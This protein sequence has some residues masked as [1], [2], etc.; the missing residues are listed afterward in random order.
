VA[1]AQLDAPVELSGSVR[2]KVKL[3]TKGGGEALVEAFL[4]EK[5]GGL[6]GGEVPCQ[7]R[8]AREDDAGFDAVA[9]A[10]CWC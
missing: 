1:L 9:G 3:G 2:S 7:E 6:K 5:K 4:V 10:W 8:G